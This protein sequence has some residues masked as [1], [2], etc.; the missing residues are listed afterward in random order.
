MISETHRFALQHDG[1]EAAESVYLV[2]ACCK[3]VGD[4]A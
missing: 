1:G 3:V 2:T 4:G